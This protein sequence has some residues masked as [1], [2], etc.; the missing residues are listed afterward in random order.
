MGIAEDS[1]RDGDSNDVHRGMNSVSTE[2]IEMEK[3][4]QC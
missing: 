2:I 4:I 1:L 3:E